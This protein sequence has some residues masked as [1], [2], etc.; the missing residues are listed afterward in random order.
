MNNG[1]PG[2]NPELKLYRIIFFW[3]QPRIKIIM[4]N[5]LPG[6][7]PELKLYCIIFF[8]I[9]PRIKIMYE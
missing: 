9:Q 8:W 5:G 1:F 6:F 4:N 2:F 3:I 7:N